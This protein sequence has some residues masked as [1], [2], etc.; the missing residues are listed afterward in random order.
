MQVGKQL[1]KNTFIILAGRVSTQVIS[2]LLLP[3]YTAVLSTEEY[4][5]VDLV[6]TYIQLLLP[7]VTCQLEQSL[8]RFLLEQRDNKD[9]QK[10]VISQLYTLSIYIITCFII[11]FI[12]VSAFIKSEYKYFLFIN[13]I[14]NIYTAFMLQTARGLGMNS[15]YAIGSFISAGGQVLLN[16]L[17]V[18]FAGYGAKGMLLSVSIAHIISGTYVLLRTKAYE[19]IRFV[20]IRKQN[21]LQYLKYSLPLVPNVISWWILY[22]SDRTIILKFLDISAN[23]IYSTANKFSGIYTTV[24]NIFHLSWTE[25]VSLNY[26]NNKND[27]LK[28]QSNV[29]RFFS[30][31]YLLLIAM[32]PLI[33]RLLVNEKFYLSY[34]QIPPLLMGSFFSAMSGVIGAYYIAEKMTVTVAKIDFIGAVVN[35]VLNLSLIHFIGLYSASVSTVVAYFIVFIIRYVD[36]KKRFGIKME[37]Q[38]SI[39]VIILSATIF[40]AYYLENTLLCLVILLITIIYAILINKEIIISIISV[41]KKKLRL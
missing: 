15:V 24:Y 16:V 36:I 28:I 12:I 11:I 9:N 21:I 4:G 1:V 13:L 32:M 31:I 40:I 19:M 3:L 35:I 22:A 33:F 38:I 30:S 26:H 2:F 18:L 34:Y 37:K 14:S 29:I 10:K 6:I 23:G 20:K 41:A 25:S 27:L 39:S 8:F 5:I 17:L 7:I